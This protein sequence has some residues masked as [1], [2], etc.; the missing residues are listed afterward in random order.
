MMTE[1]ARVRAVIAEDEHLARVSLRRLVN[2]VEWVELVG[3]AA[4]GRSAVE[5]IDRLRPDL[6]FLDVML[7]EISG[8]QALQRMRHHPLVVF[9]TAYE[10]FAVTAFEFEAVDYL[11]KPFGSRRFRETMERVRRRLQLDA[12]APKFDRLFARVGSRIVPLSV[13]DVTHFQA[14]SDYVRVFVGAASYLVCVTL[15]ELQRRLDLP[16][17]RIHRSHMVNVDCVEKVERLNGRR[18][19]VFL[20]D[21]TTV[22]ASRAGSVLLRKLM[23]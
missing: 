19:V 18:C 9:T 11:I 5:I 4:D 6:L 15:S 13:R 10:R 16:F 21:G 20:N 12:A 14:E 2:D 1:E 17:V 3:E 8:L 23:R 7:P 22:V